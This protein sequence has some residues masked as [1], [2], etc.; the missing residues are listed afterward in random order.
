M[1]DDEVLR[2][3]TAE[4]TEYQQPFLRLK[5]D[6]FL[7]Q[8]NIRQLVRAEAL[9]KGIELEDAL[10][11]HHCKWYRKQLY[12]TH[13]WDSCCL[14]DLK[15]LP[16]ETTASASNFGRSSQ[17]SCM[18]IEIDCSMSFDVFCIRF[19]FLFN[20]SQHRTSP[21]AAA[22]MAAAAAVFRWVKLHANSR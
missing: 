12:K 1:S 13:K 21:A 20:L 5:R 9:G 10:L 14:K 8:T 19:L 3:P 22:K 11:D 2:E 16:T 15:F 17:V 18:S 7:N 4:P 6:E